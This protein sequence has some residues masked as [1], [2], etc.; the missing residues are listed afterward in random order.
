M[1]ALYTTNCTPEC[2]YILIGAYT[3]ANL[4]KKVEAWMEIPCFNVQLIESIFVCARPQGMADNGKK[5]CQ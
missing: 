4:N 1:Y 3:C 2:Y 5:F